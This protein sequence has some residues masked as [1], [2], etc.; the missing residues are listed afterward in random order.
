MNPFFIWILLLT[1]PTL[2][3]ASER[4]RHVPIHGDQIIP[5]HTAFG[6]AT[7]IQ[8]PDRPNSVVVGDQ[9]GFR[10]EYLD[11]A[12]TIKPIRSG[13]KSN[14]YI[15]TD[16][17]RYNVQLVTGAEAISDF[18]VYLENP[19]DPAPNGQVTWTKANRYLTND[20]FKL[21]VQRLGRT[22]GGVL[23]M[24]FRLTTNKTATFDPTSIWI[25]QA[26]QAR[27]IQNL[28]L[29]AL[30]LSP[31]E[32]V[33]GVLE[34]LSRDVDASEALSVEVRRKKTSRLT[35]SRVASWK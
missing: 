32:P 29:S 35:I 1:F 22:K 7:I 9:E 4:V 18:V 5:I 25:T 11:Q 17:R 24:E 27:P 13:A 15:Y 33:T 2:A 8:V 12:I 34:L 3:L 16:F 10:V 26:G 28:F 20:S 31:G 6:I 23:L 14:L 19:K 30:K 21:E